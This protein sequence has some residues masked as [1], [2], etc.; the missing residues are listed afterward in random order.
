MQ[1]NNIPTILKHTRHA[2]LM[3][4]IAVVGLGGDASATEQPRN[5]FLYGLVISSKASE[6]FSTP[7]STANLLIENSMKFFAKLTDKMYTNPKITS[8]LVA[9]DPIKTSSLPRGLFG[10]VAVPFSAIAVRGQWNR[11]RSNRLYE[12]DLCTSK[13]CNTRAKNF[14]MAV[15]RGKE[16]GFAG[17]LAT[18]NIVVNGLIKYRSDQETYGRFDYWATAAETIARGAG[19]CEDF[20]ILKQT[21]LRAMGVPDKSLTIIV[22]RDNS[23]DLY[24]AVLGVSTNQGNL[25][26]DNVRDQIASDTQIPQYQPLFSFSGS[27]SWIHGTRKGSS[28]PIETS[29][30]PTAKVAPGES[31][32]APALSISLPLSELRT[33]I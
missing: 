28:T 32:P 22:L 25:I 19:D 33:S 31:I 21:M 13:R 20:A 29:Q 1:R 6:L 3:L 2:L 8:I 23:R 16:Q 26:L 5:S 9:V 17:K 14:R 30:Q 12:V 4:A 10:T 24:H 27:R 11:V 18:A 7:L 15:D